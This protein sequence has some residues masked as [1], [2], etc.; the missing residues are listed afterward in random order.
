M[1]EEL[2]EENDDDLFELPPQSPNNYSRHLSAPK[3]RFARLNDLPAAS[4]RALMFP[5]DVFDMNAGIEIEE[6]ETKLKHRR[7]RWS[8]GG[9]LSSIVFP[10]K[11]KRLSKGNDVR[12]D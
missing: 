10:A 5:D 1:M 7:S 4:P 12:E 2:A 11:L 9:S 3:S 8:K 6:P